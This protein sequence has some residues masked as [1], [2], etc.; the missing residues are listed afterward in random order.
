MLW[1]REQV[2]ATLLLLIGCVI[3][4][5]LAADAAAG[6]QGG[7]PAAPVVGNMLRRF[8]VTVMHGAGAF[9]VLLTASRLDSD[10]RSGWLVPYTASG[11][12]RVWYT[13][14]LG[15]VVT[16]VAWLVFL[17]GAGSFAVALWAVHG[18]D[19]VLSLMPRLMAAGAL[20]LAGYT[21]TTLAVGGVVRAPLGAAAVVFGLVA[22]PWIIALLVFSRSPAASTRLLEVASAVTPSL[23]V[24]GTA[25]AWAGQAMFVFGALVL[26]GAVGRLRT[27]RYP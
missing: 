4:G 8:H 27:A 9:A 7:A 10:H 23:L 2:A 1:R 26:A 12:D 24:P 16:G 17:A 3:A 19:D 25:G 21:L 20:G 18:S 6:M 11:A 14:A 13:F 15:V 22:M 5:V